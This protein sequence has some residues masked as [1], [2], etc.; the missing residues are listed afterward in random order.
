MGKLIFADSV[1]NLKSKLPNWNVSTDP[2]YYSIAFTEDGYLLTHGK[3]FALTIIG[4]NTADAVK[5]ALSN[6]KSQLL[7]TGNNMEG[8]IV[9][10]PVYSILGIENNPIVVSEE[11]GKISTTLGGTITQGLSEEALR[12]SLTNHI[13]IQ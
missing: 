10:L 7:L 9:K 2:S 12:L 8:S 3:Q 4:D 11:S 5:L 13:I 6:D 1:A